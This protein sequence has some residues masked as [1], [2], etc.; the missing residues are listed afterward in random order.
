LAVLETN[1]SFENAKEKEIFYID[2]YKTNQKNFGYNL[3]RG[4]DGVIGIKFSKDD[5]LKRSEVAKKNHKLKIIG[6]Y[7]KHHS[8]E[9]KKKIS[10]NNPKIQ[11]GTHLTK[12]TKDKISKANSGLKRSPEQIETIKKSMKQSY[13]NGNRSASGEMNGMYDKKH[14]E[15][16][17]EKMRQ[18]ALN[19]LKRFWIWNPNNSEQK[20][21]NIGEALP[22]GFILGRP[23]RGLNQTQRP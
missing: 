7:G 2:K 23:P 18:K 15:E 20:Y 3:T 6:M 1:L 8:E 16:S 5:L 12:T 13:L 17:K 9:T 22:K 19:R 21:L 14:S 4:G 10:E 11:L